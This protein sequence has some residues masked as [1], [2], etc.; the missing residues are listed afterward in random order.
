MKTRNFLLDENKIDKKLI[1]EA[2]KLL[3]KGELVAF[4]TETVYG[5]GADGLN[6]Q[7]VAKI[8]QAKSR[9]ADNPLILH[10]A[11]RKD[12]ESLVEEIPPQAEILIEK[13]WPGPLTLILKKKDLVPNLVSAGLDTV[14]I[15]MPDNPIALAL[16][17]ATAR[18]LAAPSANRSGRPSPTQASHVMEDMKGR[19][20]LIL[21]GGPTGLGL[22]STV[23]DLSREEPLILRPGAITKEQ[24]EGLLG[25]LGQEDYQ[26]WQGQARSPGQK[27]RHYA[28]KAEMILFLGSF[29]KQKEA[30]KAQAILLAKEGKKV[31]IMATDEG[32]LSYQGLG[33]VR[34]M[35][36]RQEK[37][38]IGA[39][40]FKVLRAFDDDQVDIILA[41]SV[42][43]DHIGM[44]IM[45]RLLKAA[46]G[47]TFG[48]EEE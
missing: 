40:L 12:L 6:S 13:Y 24:L 14:A 22:E 30:I 42:S 28:P 48:L 19:I 41:E 15:R 43:K 27:Y 1:E 7:A 39:N 31:G 5:L 11:S 21:D 36:S 26:D 35:G 25:G 10:I 2:A 37:G 29:D 3:K 18:P 4:P 33:L 32:K 16:I 46:D 20:P 34:S 45:N 38:K 17:E 9:P 8:F 44:A 23:L 47:K